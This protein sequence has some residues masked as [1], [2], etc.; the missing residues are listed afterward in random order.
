MPLKDKIILGPIE[1]YIRYGKVVLTMHCCLGRFPWKMVI[2]IALA[3]LTS[4]Q[5]IWIVDLT[6]N[7]S[8]SVETLWYKLFLDANV[9]KSL[10]YFLIYFRTITMVI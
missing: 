7:Y 5:A 10:W 3:V 4:L 8:Q 2:G 1:K 6:C 9:N